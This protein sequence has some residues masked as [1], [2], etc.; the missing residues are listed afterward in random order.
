MTTNYTGTQEGCD[1]L[2]IRESVT[3]YETTK[4]LICTKCRRGKIGNI[5][6]RKKA[7]LTKRGKPP[8]DEPEDYLQVKCTVCG[9]FWTVTT[10]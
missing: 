1:L 7:Y 4:P 10:E 9:T 2:R 6:N 8:P 5:P 3:A